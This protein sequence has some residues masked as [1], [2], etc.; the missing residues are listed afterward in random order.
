M[1]ERNR[2]NRAQVRT[3]NAR[4][5][6][7]CAIECWCR[8]KTW[9]ENSTKSN[10]NFCQPVER[11]ARDENAWISWDRK[12]GNEEIKELQGN[13]I[14][15]RCTKN[16]ERERKIWC[17]ERERECPRGSSCVQRMWAGASAD[18]SV[19]VWVQVKV[20]QLLRALVAPP[21]R[22]LFDL[23]WGIWLWAKG[24]Q[25][26]FFFLI[27]FGQSFQMKVSFW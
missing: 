14:W 3:H 19:Y 16:R 1:E 25:K 15:T 10:E 24:K 27:L 8:W 17:W 20:E 26:C 13:R 18:G 7:G 23:K 11:R 4:S 6:C 5:E 22:A 9:N 2:E 21:L 12:S